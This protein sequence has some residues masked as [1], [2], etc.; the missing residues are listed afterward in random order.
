MRMDRWI[1]EYFRLGGIVL[2]TIA[3]SGLG[4]LLEEQLSY[5]SCVAWLMAQD[6]SSLGLFRNK[7]QIIKYYVCNSVHVKS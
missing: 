3:Q 2:C 7:V 6:T 4:P 1:V 5:W